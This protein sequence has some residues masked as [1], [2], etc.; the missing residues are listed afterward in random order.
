MQSL[1]KLLLITAAAVIAGSCIPA[2]ASADTE[3]QLATASQCHVSLTGTVSRVVSGNEFAMVTARTGS[4]HVHY[5]GA[6]LNTHGLAIRPGVY[7]GVYGCF[8]TG[9]R[10]FQAEEVT[11]A[12]S[13]TAYAGYTRPTAAS[14]DIGPCHESVFGT[15]A[16][17]RGP[18]A[19]TLQSVHAQSTLF[20]DYRGAVAH[21]NGLAV[22][23]GVFA[24]LYG[25]FER[26]ETVF[27]TEEI[28]LAPS[29]QAYASMHNTVTISGKIDEAGNGRLGLLTRYN[30]HIHV[31]TTQ[32]G[33][34]IGEMVTARGS[35]DPITGTL[36]ATSV[37]AS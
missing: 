10:Y 12:P 11:L 20:V 26:H 3:P 27:K 18:N 8:S 31:F 32:S 13:Q 16:S 14:V 25:C 2:P 35:Y 30:G 24:G 33:F 17:V 1:R 15:I 29:A 22:R 6:R 23:P 7:A 37:T 9:Q 4:I 5:D 21:T 36:N 19:F 34:R 28:T